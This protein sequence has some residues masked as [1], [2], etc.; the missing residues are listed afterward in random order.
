MRAGEY[1]G[2]AEAQAAM[3]GLKKESFRPIPGN[4]AVYERL[5]RLYLQ[6]HDAFGG[7][8]TLT[9]LAGVMKE[10]LSIKQSANSV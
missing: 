5:Y 2:F 7:V 10:L 8:S 9:D 4:Q 1:P 3:T 6:L